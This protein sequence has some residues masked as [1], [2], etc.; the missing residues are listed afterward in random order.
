MTSMVETSIQAVSPLSMLAAANC[1]RISPEADGESVR[2]P[3]PLRILT[4]VEKLSPL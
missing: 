4:L 2:L 3:F 1:C